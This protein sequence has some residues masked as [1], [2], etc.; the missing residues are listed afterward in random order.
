M[1]STMF[2][3]F[4]NFGKKASFEAP[5]IEADN[6]L[7]SE[8]GNSTI[9]GRYSN[10]FE[11]AERDIPDRYVRDFRRGYTLDAL[12]KLPEIKTAINIWLDAAIASS[13]GDDRGV[14]VADQ[15]D[16]K[17]T[18]PIDPRVEEICTATI[19]RLF[20]AQDIRKIGRNMLRRGDDFRQIV[21]A[22][23]RVEQLVYLPTWQMFR[24]ET[25]GRVEGFYLK[26]Y[27][28]E[29][30]ASRYPPETVVHWRFRAEQ[31]YG[32]ALFEFAEN[33]AQH[34]L[35][36]FSDL[37]HAA[38]AQAIDPLV[39]EMPTCATKE[40]VRDYRIAYQAKQQHQPITDF[41]LQAGARVY[42]ASGGNSPDLNSILSALNFSQIRLLMPA[43][44]PFYLLGLNTAGA[45]EIAGEPA[46][47]LTRA[48]SNFRA[49][50][51][52]GIKQVIDLELSLQ[53]IPLEKQKYRLIWPRII[54][55]PYGQTAQTDESPEIADQE[56]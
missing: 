52:T 6:L 23:R 43:Q 13:D 8:F 47:A 15:V 29:Q 9:L 32:E 38:R 46:Q 1:V 7:L 2:K 21:I 18:I 10:P 27:T 22:N 41:F 42:R 19:D 54:V 51:T 14:A 49:D 26:E 39:H 31:K 34:L 33:D 55:N 48:I 56:K 36:R 4:F 16:R 20:S 11:A 53:G 3:R 50:I 35:K 40:Y 37:D 44:V 25:N 24:R 30:N 28:R 12:A 45:K 5:P 17:D